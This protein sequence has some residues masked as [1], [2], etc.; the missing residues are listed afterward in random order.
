M[1]FPFI[2]TEIY[3]SGNPEGFA[4]RNLESSSTFHTEVTFEVASSLIKL[5][6][7]DEYQPS[8]SEE[9]GQS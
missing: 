6:E 7:Y 1:N 3:I 2:F 9:Q 8:E 4:P 5:D